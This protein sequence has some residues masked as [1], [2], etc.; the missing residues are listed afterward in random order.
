MRRRPDSTRR[1][2]PRPERFAPLNDARGYT[3]AQIRV[4]DD[5]DREALT[6][7]A[8]PLQGPNLAPSNLRRINKQPWQDEIWGLR[9]ENGELRFLIDRPSKAASMAQLFIARRGEAGEAPVRVISQTEA[10]EGVV[11]QTGDEDLAAL[12]RALFGD[13]PQTA[14]TIKRAVQH[15]YGNGETI[16]RVSQDDTDGYALHA[17]S[18][19]EVSGSDGM[20]KVNDGQQSYDVKTTDV[21]CRGWIPDPQRQYLP[22]CPVRSV[23][24][25]AR[26]LVALTKFVAAQVDSRLAGAGILI[27]PQE[28]QIV[29][30]NGT[31]KVDFVTEL[32]QYMITPISDRE[33]AASV[34]PYLIK[35]PGEHVDKVKHITFST[36]LDERLSELR[37]ETIRRLA[38]GVDSPPEVL[39]G[40][41]DAN[42][43][44]AWQVGEDEIK[45]VIAPLLGVLAHTLTVGWLR[46][47]VDQLGLD[48]DDYVI[49]YDL[50]PLE[51]RPDKSEDA[52]ALHDKGLLSAAAVRRENGFTEDDEPS[53]DEKLQTFAAQLLQALP[54]LAN[55]LAPLM[56]V[57][58]PAPL[59]I[60][61][62]V[63]PAQVTNT[64]TAT[65]NEITN[66]L[67]DTQ[68]QDPRP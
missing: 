39:L 10:P 23:M 41:G 2:R 60:P 47:A 56:G 31:G 25:V 33:S 53:D 12:S 8:E 64:E 35:M 42:H 65:T 6:A 55:D 62:G 46:G 20:W 22:D 50:T 58:L 7:A 66:N 4:S 13:G 27:L 52:K 61:S 43:W 21:L 57:T 36:P 26:E 48:P 28:A 16:L 19:Q 37:E 24:P 45:M 11:V 17:H 67:P 15:L 3:V 34:V 1:R 5:D 38:L 14:Q 40:M 30:P 32:G 9:A 44:S 49:W 63:Q 29:Q 51:L 18:V 59:E 68:G 54:Q